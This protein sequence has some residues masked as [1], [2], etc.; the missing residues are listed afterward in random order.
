MASSGAQLIG[1]AGGGVAIAALGAREALL[2]SAGCQVFAAVV[3]RLALAS[4][5]APG[6]R[7]GS[8]ALRQSWVGTA[9]L[10][11]DRSVRALFLAQ[12]LPPAYVVGAESLLVPYAAVRGLPAGAPGLLLACIPIGMLAGDLVIGR[13]VGPVRR[14]KLFTPLVAL[15]GGPLVVVAADPPLPVL[16]LLLAVSGCGFGY[17]L[18]LQRRFVDALP[19]DHRGHAFALLSTGLMTA[20]GAGPLL[21]GTLSEFTGVGTAIAVAGVATLTTGV[22]LRHAIRTGAAP[23]HAG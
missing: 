18:T 6:V 7:T 22:A 23:R 1:L 15:L 4:F 14:E 17:S 10:L 2:V 20:Q 8:S 16:A 11:A 9:Q 19:V 5:P 12:W 21:F 3:A 13:F